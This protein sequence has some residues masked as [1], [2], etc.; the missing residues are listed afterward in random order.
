MPQIYEMGPMALLPLRRKACWGFFRPKNPTASAGFEPANFGTK[1]QHA[2]PRPPKPYRYGTVNS[3]APFMFHT[4]PVFVQVETCSSQKI[5]H[6]LRLITRGPFKKYADCFYFSDINGHP[7]TW[8]LQSVFW[9]AW[10]ISHLVPS[11]CLPSASFDPRQGQECWFHR[12]QDDWENGPKIVHYVLSKTTEKLRTK[13]FRAITQ[14]V[15]VLPY[16][17]FILILTNLMQYIL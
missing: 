17:L 6:S 4:P 9:H 3:P 10:T 12:I 5:K 14:R 8:R 15:V 1:G 2:T 16:R 13:L 7:G 11:L